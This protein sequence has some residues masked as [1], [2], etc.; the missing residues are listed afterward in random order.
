MLHGCNMKSW[1][2]A[3]HVST[4]L[5]ARARA[6]RAENTKKYN[7]HKYRGPEITNIQI[8]EPRAVDAKIEMY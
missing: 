3:D 7:N 4:R 1:Q 5:L 6:R 2:K 8:D